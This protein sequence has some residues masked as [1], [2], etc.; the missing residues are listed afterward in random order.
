MDEA[1]EIPMPVPEIPRLP[2][3]IACSIP[4]VATLLGNLVVSFVRNPDPYGAT[5]LWVP[6]VV[7]FIILVLTPLFHQAVRVRYRGR[8]L[9]FLNCA[10]VLGEIIIC[11]ALWFGS[12]F[13]LVN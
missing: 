13:L 3:W 11:L 2:L 4:P 9:V 5:F 12:C 7:F 10:Y 6:V 8:S 1:P